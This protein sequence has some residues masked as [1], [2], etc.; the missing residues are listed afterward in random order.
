MS[1]SIMV[2]EWK[3]KAKSVLAPAIEAELT[4][5]GWTHQD[6]ARHAGLKR[7]TI[8]DQ[9]GDYPAFRMLE[10]LARSLGLDPEKILVPAAAQP[11]D[12]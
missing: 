7:E 3:K 6:L 12:R 11:S 4:A 2:R 9:L 5:R 10:D 1:W 8:D